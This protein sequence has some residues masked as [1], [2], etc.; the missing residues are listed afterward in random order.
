IPL[1]ILLGCA[2]AVRAPAPAPAGEAGGAAREAPAA[3]AATAAAPEI[4]PPP[5]YLGAV[6]AGTRTRTG[7]PGERYWQN[8]AEYRME[9]RVL[10]EAQ[11]LEGRSTIVY[12]NRSPEVLEI[13]VLD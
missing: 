13:L 6:A 8:E 2:P 12:H 11:R 5:A 7:H 10:P 9:L 1:S 3:P 4:T